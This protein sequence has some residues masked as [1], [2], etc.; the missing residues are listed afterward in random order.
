MELERIKGGLR[1]YNNF[2]MENSK[3]NKNLKQNKTYFEEVNI[4]IRL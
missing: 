4:V 2:K 1:L 3:N